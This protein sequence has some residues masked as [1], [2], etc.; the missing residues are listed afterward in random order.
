MIDFILQQRIRKRE[1]DIAHNKNT[2]VRLEN[3][4]KRASTELW[5]RQLQTKIDQL[6]RDNETM[7]RK[8]RRKEY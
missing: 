5:K 4:L 7:E 2:I 1:A 8:N 6:K 3:D